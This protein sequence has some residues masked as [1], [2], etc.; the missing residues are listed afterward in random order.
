MFTAL[1]EN[2]GDLNDKINLFVALAPV[3]YLQDSTDALM[4][5]AADFFPTLQTTFE[6]L[7]VHELFGS[8]WSEV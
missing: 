7:A 1:A 3:T 5:Y 4:K 8:T 6:E 2:F